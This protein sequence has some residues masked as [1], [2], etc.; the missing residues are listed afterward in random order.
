MTIGG[1][2]TKRKT[3]RL[4]GG[5][6][7][8]VE[9]FRDGRYGAP[10]AKRKKKEK[11]TPEQVERINYLN[12][13]KR[14]RHKLIEYFS[15]GDLFIT[16]TYRKGD[17]PPDMRGALKDFATFRRRIIRAYQKRGKPLY[18]IRNIE[19]GTRGAWHVHLVINEIGDTASIVKDAWTKGGIYTEEIGRST[20]YD[21]DFD[22]LAS[23]MT[24][25]EKT[26]KRVSEASY[27][28]SRNMPVPPPKIEK[29]VRWKAKIKPKKGYTVIKIYEGVNEL[30]GHEYRRYT[31]IRSP[32]GT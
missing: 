7:I 11:P 17:R 23:Y 21:Q 18:W 16:L 26:E 19:R 6:V 27:G 3:Y 5:T 2:M 15:K 12:K 28:T 20:Y 1:D 8:E 32:G 4:R 13:K 22:R 29:L 31:M 24:K 10:G 25:D 9:E 30:T 14:C